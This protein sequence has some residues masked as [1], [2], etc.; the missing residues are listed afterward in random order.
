LELCG[1]ECNARL[2]AVKVLSY[3]KA[4]YSVPRYC[5]SALEIMH[6]SPWAWRAALIAFWGTLQ[7]SHR[8]HDRPHI[9]VLFTWSLAF[10]I[11][12]NFCRFPQTLHIVA[13]FPYCWCRWQNIRREKGVLILCDS[14]VR[15]LLGG[16]DICLV[17]MMMADVMTRLTVIDRMIAKAHV[18]LFNDTVSNSRMTSNDWYVMGI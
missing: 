18:S 6:E 7:F 5:V 1:L 9:I 17:D 15:L 13:R 3:L 2:W 8:L 16:T 11:L 4:A 10:D 14:L 12:R